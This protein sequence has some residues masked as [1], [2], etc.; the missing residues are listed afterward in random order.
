MTTKTLFAFLCLL[1]LAASGLHAATID[2]G[3]PAA[4]TP[5]DQYLGPMWAVMHGLGS[6]NPSIGRVEELV[7]QAAEFR[8]VYAKN[9]PYIPQSPRVTGATGSG[10]C[11]AKALWLAAKMRSSKVRFVIGK[12][13]WFHSRNH[14]WLMWKGPS[15]WLILDPSHH[16]RPLSPQQVSAGQF[17]PLYSY[18]PSG[19]YVHAKGGAARWRKEITH[20]TRRSGKTPAAS[21]PQ[22]SP[23]NAKPTG[24]R[25][26]SSGD[27]TGAR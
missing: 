27:R 14:A 23:S 20:G 11:K 22:V 2:L 1:G 8:Y 25:S 19:S 7:R 16:S 4:R 15:G 12:A 21:R 24:L 17:I 5:Y 9:Q 10:D 13:S 6:G 18:D 26:G 3:S